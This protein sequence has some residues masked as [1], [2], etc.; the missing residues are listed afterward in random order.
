MGFSRQGYWSG[1]PFRPPGDLP[2]PGIELM[3]PAVAG[4]LFT[5]EPQ[6]KSAREALQVTCTQKWICVPL[7]SKQEDVYLHQ[8]IS[9]KEGPASALRHWYVNKKVIFSWNSH[10]PNY[11][12]NSPT[13]EISSYPETDVKYGRN[14]HTYKAETDSH[15]DQTCGLQGRDRWVGEARPGG[16]GLTYANYYI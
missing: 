2:D 4:G 16:W 8:R 12:E 15:S 10:D 7:E 13:C 9:F 11:T 6:G 3:Y 5:T 14:E 1:L